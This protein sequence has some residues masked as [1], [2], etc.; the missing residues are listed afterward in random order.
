MNYVF[1]YNTASKDT[2]F[3]WIVQGDFCIIIVI[4]CNRKS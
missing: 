3:F 4:D 2:I 1:V